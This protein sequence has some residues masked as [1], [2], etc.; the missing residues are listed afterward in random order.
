MICEGVIVTT[1]WESFLFLVMFRKVN[2]TSRWE[3]VPA[4]G[5]VQ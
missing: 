5:L 3:K 1:K 4:E 2:A